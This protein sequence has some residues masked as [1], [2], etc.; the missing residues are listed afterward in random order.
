MKFQR[1]FRI[2]RELPNL[3]SW[4]RTIRFYVQQSLER[5][6][7]GVARSD[8]WGFDDYVCR[9]IIRGI[10]VLKEDK[11]GYP[12]R[13]MKVDADGVPIQTDDEDRRCKAEWQTILD[14][15]LRTF[16]LQQ[17]LIAYELYP[18]DAILNEKH[19]QKFN[20]R[21]MTKEEYDAMELGWANFK[22]YFG[23]LWS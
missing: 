12:V 1:V 5:I 13:L 17:Q 3:L 20:I 18:Y 8:T 10:T 14:S 22:T 21:K 16:Q 9:V 23:N 11:I 2:L 6:R 7:Y 4:Y 15:M 19:A